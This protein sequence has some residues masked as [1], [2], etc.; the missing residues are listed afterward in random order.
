[1]YNNNSQ[2]IV[3]L[4]DYGTENQPSIDQLDGNISCGSS[5]VMSEPYCPCCDEM[6]DS[7]TST[8]YD[9]DYDQGGHAIPVLGTLPQYDVVYSDPPAWYDE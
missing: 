4:P 1:M 3:H 8:S 2:H 6:S 5:S 7:W 9:Q